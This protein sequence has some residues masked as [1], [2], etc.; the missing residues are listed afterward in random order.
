M[1]I[2]IPII[3]S[4]GFDPVWFAVLYIVNMQ[5]AF[6]T[7]PYGVNLFYMKA[8]A[9]KGINMVDI[10]QSVIP[11][12]AIQA[13]GLTLFMLFPQLILYLPNKIF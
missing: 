3:K 6:I 11:F 5:M 13:I 10:Y 1:P 2:Y 4:L 7:P 12:V 9:P 8:V